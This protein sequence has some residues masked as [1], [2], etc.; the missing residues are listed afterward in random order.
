VK[1]VPTSFIPELALTIA[2]LQ[3]YATADL[4]I[5]QAEETM[6]HENVQSF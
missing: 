1:A 5:F 6:I 3:T 2:Y 4:I